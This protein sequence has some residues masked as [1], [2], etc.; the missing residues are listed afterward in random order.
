MLFSVRNKENVHFPQASENVQLTSFQQQSET[1]PIAMTPTRQPLSHPSLSPNG[2]LTGT[3]LAG[4]YYTNLWIA[5]SKS[6]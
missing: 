6:V 1:K 4:L 5:L 3:I 2:S